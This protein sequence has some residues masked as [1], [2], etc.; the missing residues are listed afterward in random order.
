MWIGW[1]VWNQTQCFFSAHLEIAHAQLPAPPA[2]FISHSSSLRLTFS[3]VAR[4]AGLA[5][6]KLPPAMMVKLLDTLRT[7][8]PSVKLGPAIGEDA[9][10]IKLGGDR[11][12]ISKTDPITFT[13]HGAATLLMQVNAND[14]ATRGAVPRYLQVAA[15][16]PPGT[17]AG[18]IRRCFAELQ[19]EA[20]ILGVTITGGHTE[21]TEAV[22]RPVL[23]GNMLGFV[24]RRHLI[25]T[26]DARPGDV[27][28]MAGA[29]GIEGS[30]ILAAERGPQIARALGEAARLEAERLAIEPGISI[31]RPARIAAALGAHAMHDPTEGGIGAAI[32]EMA[33]AA[34]LRVTVHLERILVLG[35]TRK[36]CDLLRIDPLGLTSS[37]ALLV[38]IGPARAERLIKALQKAHIPASRIGG[39]E[40][41]RGVRAM[42]DSKVA[43]LPWFERDEI[44]KLI[45]SRKKSPPS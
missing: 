45:S 35:I 31:V 34:A 4:K 2:I 7:N 20:R 37:G 17:A 5:P 6:G 30:A 36:I 16:F 44:V 28:V 1:Y 8:D 22:T 27:L 3:T 19:S 13:A 10:A 26:G 11:Y 15:F 41:G 38:A 14:L 29:A 32:H 21:V 43:R 33:Y 23:V 18:T 9:A 24:T 25:S 40:A 39:F 12:L 42:L